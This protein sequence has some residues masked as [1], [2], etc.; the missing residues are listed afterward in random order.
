MF[1][2][3]WNYTTCLVHKVYVNVI[4]SFNT[5]HKNW[6]HKQTNIWLI[7]RLKMSLPPPL[8]PLSKCF[9][10]CWSIMFVSYGDTTSFLLFLPS[11]CRHSWCCLSPQQ[12]LR[13]QEDL[14]GKE[15]ELEQARDEQRYLEG[16]VLN[17]REKVGESFEFLYYAYSNNV[18]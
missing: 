18:I 2:W 17:L 4:V 12:L 15:L 8:F 10:L 3:F 7:Y 14:K 6:P 13:L 9:V 1:H 11:A 16:E 5:N